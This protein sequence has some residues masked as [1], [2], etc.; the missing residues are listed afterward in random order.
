MFTK[1][2]YIY[3]IL[4]YRSLHGHPSFCPVVN[5]YI[6]P[7][8]CTITLKKGEADVFP[9]LEEIDS[10]LKV[11]L[12]GIL[13]LHRAGI[14]YGDIKVEN[15]IR[16]QDRSFKLIDLDVVHF[17]NLTPCRNCQTFYDEKHYIANNSEE[18]VF[19]YDTAKEVV[20]SLGFL[21]FVICEGPAFYS[22]MYSGGLYRAFLKT[23]VISSKTPSKWLPFA[24]ACF[25]PYTD[26]PNSIIDLLP[27]IPIPIQEYPFKYDK[28]T[29]SPHHSPF[30]SYLDYEE[31]T[32][33]IT[34]FLSHFSYFPWND[35]R[36]MRIYY[37]FCT[38][39]TSNLTCNETFLSHYSSK[40]TMPF[41]K[42]DH[43]VFFSLANKLQSM[44][45]F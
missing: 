41:E 23:P 36:E 4:L 14:V 15:V 2:T 16:L 37:T 20:W 12:E 43:H 18:E 38:W 27:L 39:L 44:P 5:D 30:S 7:D 40:W 35:E 13:T 9:T 3:E 25:L 6:G 29:L 42:E 32:G 17:Q 34:K 31:E 11:V 24:K 8:D 19:Y 28:N 45:F 10:Y 26:R 22:T 1:R 21:L 33:L